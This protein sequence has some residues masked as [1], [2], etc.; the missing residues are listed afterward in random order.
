MAA[1]TDTLNGS[2]GRPVR[3]AGLD[4]AGQSRMTQNVLGGWAAQLVFMASGFVIPRLIDGQI[5]QAALGVWDFAWSVIGSFTLAQLGIVSSINRYVARYRATGDLDGVNRTVS[6]VSCLLLVVGLVVM[7]LTLA[8]AYGLPHLLGPQLGAHVD[9]ARW[10]LLL[11]GASLTVSV[12][13]SGYSGVLTGCHRWALHNAIH[14]GGQCLTFGGMLGALYL[15]YG[16]KA[17]ALVHLGGELANRLTRC[18]VAYRTIPGLQVRP[19]HVRWSYARRMLTFGGKSFLPDIANLLV[20]QA[21]NVFIV[22]ALGPA[23]LALYARPMAL[24]RFANVLTAKLAMVLTPTASSL[25]HMGQED[26]LRELITSASRYTAYLVWPVVLGLSI[27]GHLVLRLWMGPGYD[28]ELLL[29]ILAV[30]HLAVLSQQP[31]HTVLMGLNAHGRPGLARLA[32]STSSVALIALAIG[33]LQLGL[34][35]VALAVTVPQTIAN[36]LYLPIYA[37]RRLDMPVRQY[38]LRTWRGPLLCGLPFALC[39]VG[40]RLLFVERPLFSLASGSLVGGL[41]LAL[42]YWRYALPESIKKQLTA[43]VWRRRAQQVFG[44]V[45]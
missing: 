20:R 30:G 12:V 15:G 1:H 35:G 17:L 19:A 32:A 24:L 27:L 25:Q 23:A 31:V 33:P 36:G 29:T 11:L 22:A 39:L 42:L 43:L 7:G 16:L 37:C 6:S 4:P 3:A 21:T 28:Q 13:S 14:A 40:A 26:E 2:T 41:V 45:S 9:E 38:L 5:G 18:V 44:L 34:V 10:V 8:A